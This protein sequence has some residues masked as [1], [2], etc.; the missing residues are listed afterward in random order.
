MPLMKPGRVTRSS[1]CRVVAV[2]ARDRVLDQL[3]RLG[4][5]HRADGLEALHDWP[6]CAV[7]RLVR[8]G[9]PASTPALQ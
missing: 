3:A 7:E 5:G 2:D 4:V 9:A 6:A 1:M 8:P